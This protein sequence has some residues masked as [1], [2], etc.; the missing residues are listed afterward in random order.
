[1]YLI[2]KVIELL[3]MQKESRNPYDYRQHFHWKKEAISL[4]KKKTFLNVLS[5]LKNGYYNSYQKL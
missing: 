3:V 2:N 5:Q 4:K 1:M